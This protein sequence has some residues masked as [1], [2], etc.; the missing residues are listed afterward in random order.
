MQKVIFC[1][2]CNILC[3]LVYGWVEDIAPD[4]D[5]ASPQSVITADE[6]ET[7]ILHI[8]HTKN[9]RSPPGG[10]GFN[11]EAGGNAT[12]NSSQFPN[13]VFLPYISCSVILH[14]LI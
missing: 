3:S 4:N 2:V 1:V 14:T 6:G 10:F 7:I 13:F 5:T 9:G 8:F 12:C 11:I